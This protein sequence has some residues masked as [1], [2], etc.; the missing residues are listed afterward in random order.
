MPAQGPLSAK[1]LAPLMT[2]LRNGLNEVGDVVSI[3]QAEA[4][5]KDYEARGP[6]KAVSAQELKA[7]YMKHLP[8]D[9][10]EPTTIVDYETYLPVG[11]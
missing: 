11:N 7:D 4:A 10:M 5:I 3:E 1:D 2:Y 8:G 6:G 9:T